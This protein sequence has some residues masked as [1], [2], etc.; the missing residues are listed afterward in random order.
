MCRFI[1]LSFDMTNSPFLDIFYKVIFML[2]KA[3]E[4]KNLF[5][6]YTKKK[7]LQNT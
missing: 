7:E 2:L 3:K 1:R 5:D 6:Y 4:A